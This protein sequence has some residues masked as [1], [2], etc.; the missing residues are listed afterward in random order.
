MTGFKTLTITAPE[1]VRVRTSSSDA[2]FPNPMRSTAEEVVQ[3]SN[4]RASRWLT[5]P[6]MAVVALVA[7]S[8]MGDVYCAVVQEPSRKNDKTGEITP[9]P[10]PYGVV[11]RTDSWKKLEADSTS[12]DIR[13]GWVALET[14]FTPAPPV[15]PKKRGRKPDP[16][17]AAE[18]EAK[19]ASKQPKAQL[20]PE[21][22]ARLE[23]FEKNRLAA[24]KES[25]EATPPADNS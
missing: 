6:S 8:D 9:A 3:T 1:G 12:A 14:I 24:L 15:E 11:L 16:A 4:Q 21:Q 25:T 2:R 18:R 20:T 22:Q 10:E 7:S 19:K 13:S 5:I 17:K 23:A